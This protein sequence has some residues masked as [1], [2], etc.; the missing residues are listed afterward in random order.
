MAA[1]D[2]SSFNYTTVLN[3]VAAILFVRFF[4]IGSHENAGA[5]ELNP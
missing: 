2:W 5:M 3:I 1:D 4:S